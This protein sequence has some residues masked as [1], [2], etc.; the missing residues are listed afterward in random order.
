VK[1][2]VA[3]NVM[4]ASGTD[5]LWFEPP[6][7]TNPTALNTWQTWNALTGNWYDDNGTL[8][9]RPGDKTVSLAALIAAL[10]DA[11]IVNAD[12]LGGIRLGVG[13][14]SPTD[15]FNAT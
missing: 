10:P 9:S 14:A 8:R 11:T 13:F 2:R 1:F 4:T 7:Q 12:G 3:I 5:K 6:Y 15:Q